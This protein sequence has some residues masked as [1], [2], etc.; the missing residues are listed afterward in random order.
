M[1]NLTD[2]PQFLS[3][4]KGGVAEKQLGLFLSTVAGAVI[5]HGKAGKVT[6]E[7]TINQI[8]DSNQVE[9][10]HK[11]NFKV[12]TET[13]DKTENASGKTP[14]HVLQGGKLSLM[15]ERVKAEDYLNG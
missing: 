7:L 8:S 2:V 4:L 6:L 12:P 15:P 3:D 13:G 9:V 5:T 14:M 1:N 10:A 11:I